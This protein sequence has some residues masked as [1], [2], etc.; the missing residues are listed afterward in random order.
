MTDLI[1]IKRLTREQWDDLTPSF[2][3]LSYRQ[4][5]SYAEAAARD[6]GATAEFVA[7]YRSTALIGMACLR[8]K[9]VPIFRLGIAYLDYGPITARGK[10]PSIEMFCSCLGALRRE[11]VEKR[12]L[13]LRVVPP[14]RGGG[15]R[16]EANGL[17]ISGFRRSERHKPYETFILDLST[18]LA[19]IRKNFDG[20]WRGH[21]SKAQRSNIEVTRSLTLDDFDRLEPMFHSLIKSK[22]FST[23][24]DVAFFRRVQEGEQSAQKL[25]IHFAWHKGELIAGH[26]GSFV[27][28]TAVYLVGAATTKGRELRASYLLQWAVIEHAKSVGNLFYDLGGIDAQ[29]NPSVY[30]FKKGVGGR[31]VTEAGTYE[32]APGPLTSRLLHFMEDVYARLHSLSKT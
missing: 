15:W 1:S 16:A 14:L 25:A 3:D 29:A 4:C 21:L 17:E 5:G 23:R 20:K 11:Y 9:M 27:G 19:D 32:L 24:R 6:V 12:R 22:G 30:N 8:I 13:M 2:C 31:Q 10:D 18:S 26:I 7:I 28:D